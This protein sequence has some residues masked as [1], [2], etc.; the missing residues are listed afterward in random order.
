MN[1]VWKIR[2][3]D[4]G[5]ADVGTL[6]CA[7][8]EITR[9][10]YYCCGVAGTPIV[11]AVPPATVVSESVSP[12]NNAPDP[13]ETVTM[14]FPLRNV[15]TGLSTNLVATLL[16]GGGV[17]APSAPQ[18]Y[19]SLS[20][21][22]PAAARDFTFV[23]SGNCGEN[24]TAT[25]QLQDGPLDLGTV[26]YSIRLGSTAVGGAS[27]AN[28]TKINIPAA[29][30]GA[31]TG[32]PAGP[33]PSAINISGVTGT[34]SK[35]TATLTG[36]SHTFP[37]DVDILLVGPGGQ[38]IVLMS[39]VGSGTDAVNANITFDDSAPAIG[40]TV[41]AGTFRPT[42]SG[43]G[44]LFPAPAPAAPYGSALSAFNGISPNGTWSL[45]VVDDAGTDVGSIVGGWSLNITTS[46]PFC[47]FQACTLGVPA[48][49]T[50]NNDPGS[51]GAFV[52][53]PPATVNG[54]CGVVTYAPS[55]GSFF[56]VGPAAVIV[57][58][59]RQDS[60][61]T[62]AG[63][64]V[65]VNDVEAPAVGPVSASPDTL[66]TPNHR[67]HDVVLSY[68]SGPDNCGGAVSCQVVSVTSNEPS[69]GLGDGD[70][71]P[72]WSIISPTLVQLRA[73]R[74]GL[75][76]GRVYTITVRCT[77]ATGN[78]AFRQTTVKVPFSQK[79]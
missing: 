58:G 67:M 50:Q 62:T 40:T 24:I 32:A 69:N 46:D 74:S 28:A 79:H 71:A 47:A 70:A 48:D 55:S 57:T 7:T 4:T 51:C 27:G 65:T 16:P 77:D 6:G 12:A 49:I 54:S 44:D 9:Q 64:N 63:F 20:P 75:G 56:P 61:T 5:S 78:H 19:G 26:S 34:V 3:T 25:F 10:L 35:V 37:G 73:E 8:L 1:G 18:S 38:K 72:D 53:Y 33:Y 2:I 13:D 23:P 14:S 30:T 52:N 22:G 60:S 76:S 66:W 59:T 11:K 68:T 21:I 36:F 41:V 29:G 15:G 42:N 17:N 43:T 39:D 45:Y 31:S